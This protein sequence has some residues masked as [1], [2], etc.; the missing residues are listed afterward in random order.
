MTILNHYISALCVLASFSA[1]LT[2]CGGRYHEQSGVVWNTTYHI[3]WNSAGDCGDSIRAVMRDVEMSLS[4]FADESVISSINRSESMET[5]FRIER[6]FGVSRRVNR[7]SGGMFDPTV[8]PLVNLWGFGYTGHDSEA[9]DQNAIDSALTL[10]GIDE[11]GIAGGRMIKKAPGT[12]FNFSAVTKGFG[13]DEVAA[14]LR[15]HGAKDY[16]VEIGGELALGGVNRRGEPWRIQIDAPVDN[17]T[18]VTHSRLLVI[19]VTDCG[20]ATSGNYRNFRRD[21]RGR[22]YGHTISPVTGRPVT[23]S[24]LSATVIAPT[25]MEADAL[26]TACMAMPAFAAVEMIDRLEATECLL[27]TAASDGSWRLL[28][29]AG[30]PASQENN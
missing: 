14:M 24:T 1:F 9:P 29:S 16:M 10:V 20:V 22:P 4:P 15:R 27:V 5:D 17:D 28:R 2:S 18:S 30:F 3:C 11:C 25:C 23:T 8:A 26:A 6:V 12:Q 21:D 19:S 7:L 13:C